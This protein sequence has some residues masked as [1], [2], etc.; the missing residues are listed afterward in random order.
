VLTA[1]APNRK[2]SRVCRVPQIA[3]HLGY[4]LLQWAHR[5]CESPLGVEVAAAECAARPK[6]VSLAMTSGG[7]AALRQQRKLSTLMSRWTTFLLFTCCIASDACWRNVSSAVLLTYST[8]TQ[9]N[10]GTLQYSWH[11]Q[12]IYMSREDFFISRVF[13]YLFLPSHLGPF[14]ASAFPALL[15]LLKRGRARSSLIIWSWHRIPQRSQCR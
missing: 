1:D 11:Q 14:I 3:L 8:Q 10:A 6:S 4:A 13:R 5:T 2:R 9:R 15:R 7:L 12:S